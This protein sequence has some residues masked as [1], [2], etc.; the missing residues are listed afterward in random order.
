MFDKSLFTDCSA[1][2]RRTTIK[3][4]RG[5]LATRSPVFYNILNSASRKSQKN[6]IEI[7]NFHVEVVKKML[8]YIYTE[9]VSDIEHIASE[10]LAIAIEYALDKLKEIAIEYLCV[11]LTIE[12]VYKHFILSE[13][14]SS[15]ELRKCC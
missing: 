6:I 10:V 13:K 1:K 14:I 5:V 4:H 7:K 15:K 12:N 8:R 11:D 2:V 9:D 3:V